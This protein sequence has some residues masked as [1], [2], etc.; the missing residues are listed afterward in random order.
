MAG[1]SRSI[2]FLRIVI[3][4]LVLMVTVAHFWFWLDPASFAKIGSMNPIIERFGGPE[5]FD[6]RER[7]LGFFITALPEAAL[8]WAM[9]LLFQLTRILSA[10]NWF[11]EAS[12]I[13]CRRI[14][15]WLVIYVGLS[16]LHRSL[17]SIALTYADGPG[18]RQLAISFSN[19]DLMALVPALLAVVI[20]HMIKLARAQRDELREII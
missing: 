14:G 4:A 12:E 10:G 8:I 1:I 19:H 16:I 5:N 11:D 13:C 3:G 15:R 6:T 17:L 18:E 9:Y 2:L 7:W 20:G